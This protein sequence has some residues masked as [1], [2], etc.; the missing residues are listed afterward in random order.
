MDDSYEIKNYRI[1][2][3]ELARSEFRE[4]RTAKTRKKNTHLKPKKKKR[5]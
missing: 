2:E 1:K 5:K 4:G 3:E